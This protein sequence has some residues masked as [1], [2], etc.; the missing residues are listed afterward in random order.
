M[1]FIDDKINSL[2]EKDRNNFEETLTAVL[3]DDD[4]LGFRGFDDET[5]SQ[6]TLRLVLYREMFEKDF[7]YLHR[8][9]E[10]FA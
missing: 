2:S 9:N 10:R 4:W 1:T 3:E 5:F 6:D 7:S 8:Y